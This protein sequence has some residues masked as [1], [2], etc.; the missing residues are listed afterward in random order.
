MLLMRLPWI[1]MAS[2]RSRRIPSAVDQGP[3]RDHDGLFT[4]GAHA[5]LPLIGQQ[6]PLFPSIVI[7]HIS[8][9][10]HASAEDRNEKN[11]PL[12]S[13]SRRDQLR[14]PEA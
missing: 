2:F 10:Y 4:M 13:Y 14:A 9:L 11:W 6:S 8:A 3:I 7:M 1:T 12:L 5:N